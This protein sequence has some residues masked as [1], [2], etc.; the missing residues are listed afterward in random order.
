M[1]DKININDF[2]DIDVLKKMKPKAILD[3]I[4]RHI[5]EQGNTTESDWTVP[6]RKSIESPSK[7]EKRKWQLACN[8]LIT[9][10]YWYGGACQNLD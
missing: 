7:T 9:Y 6:I 3:I 1:E 10:A 5:L 8:S 2:D 4:D